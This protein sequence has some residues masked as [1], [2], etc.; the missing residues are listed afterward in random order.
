AAGGRHGGL[1][2]RAAGQEPLAARLMQIGGE[3]LV[4]G[5]VQ[6]G[7]QL[8]A[9]VLAAGPPHRHR[10]H[11]TSGQP[12][13]AAGAPSA[14]LICRAAARTCTAMS[15][16]AAAVIRDAGPDT[17]ML[18]A[19]WPDRSNTGAATQHRWSSSSSRSSA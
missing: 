11:A 9:G 1:G 18:A 13:I 12:G 7:G 14:A 4:F 6:Q 3:A 8:G 17:L 2:Q 5:I 16:T 10:T 19:T 15:G